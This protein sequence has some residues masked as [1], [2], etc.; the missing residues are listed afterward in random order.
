M[1]TKFTYQWG[2]YKRNRTAYRSTMKAI[3]SIDP[4]YEINPD[5]L[6]ELLS[7]LKFKRPADSD[8]E[9]AFLTTMIDTIPGMKKDD[10]GNRIL[11]IPLPNGDKSTT[12]FSCHTDT[13]HITSGIQKVIHDKE[14]RMLSKNDGECLGADDGAGCF[15]LFQLIK[16]QIPGLYLFHREE[17]IGGNGSDYLAKNHSELFDNINRMI[18]FDRKGTQDIITCQGHTCASD[19]FA[20]HLADKLRM[21]HCPDPTGTF[22]D[23]ANYTHLIAECTNVSIG[24]S[25][26]HTASEDLDYEYLFKLTDALI[27]VNFETLT[28]KRTPEE[29]DPWGDY[30]G[31]SYGYGHFYEPKQR[32]SSKT[33]PDSFDNPYELLDYDSAYELLW[34]QPELAA[35]ILSNLNITKAE[36]LDYENEF[37]GMDEQLAVGMS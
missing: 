5:Y 3:R 21:D 28:T 11:A 8:G 16:N 34:N 35:Y 33:K 10:F 2:S 1:K 4:N 32:A 14:T 23:S 20:Y 24:Y 27:Q 13:V 15:I 22:T 25:G 30:Y 18:A 36:V 6:D 7:I 9:E 37:E 26:A 31:N 29:N 19:Q 17:E 12:S